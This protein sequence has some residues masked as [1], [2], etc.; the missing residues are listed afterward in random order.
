V[1]VD[2]KNAEAAVTSG[3]EVDFSF[4]RNWQKYLR[5]LTPE[6]LEQNRESLKTS[7]RRDSLE[8]L[9]F[10]DAGCGSGVFSQA[11]LDLGA[12][13]VISV[14]VDPYSISCAR[15]LRSR[16]PRSERWRIVPGS[17]L[18]PEFVASLPQVDVVYSWGVLHHTGAMWRAIESVLPLVKADGV[19][20]LALYRAPPK[21]D[22]HMRLKRTYNRLPRPA[23]PLLA[24]A[25]WLN[26]VTQ[27]SL[28]RRQA[29][30]RYVV[31]YGRESRGMSLWRDV[32]DWLGGLPCE[33][34]EAAEVEAFVEQ[35]GFVVE[36][37][38]ERGPGA[39][40]EYLLSRSS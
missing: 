31:Q 2:Y 7:L 39:N 13:E 14:D 37:L 32:E 36:H 9:T 24:V 27:S 25:Y 30:W 20:L 16:H 10:L 17:L 28:S 26:L 4:G 15:S 21:V 22:V 3:E 8:G 19:C 40:N 1:T 12:A 23:R 33:F 11:A 38:L 35:H 18:Q 6:R 5:G 29:P 34:A